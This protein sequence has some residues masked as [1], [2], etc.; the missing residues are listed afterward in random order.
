MDD[1]IFNIGGTGHP[2]ENVRHR[3]G[4][5]ITTSL[6]DSQDIMQRQNCFIGQENNL[7]CFFDKLSWTTKL[8]LL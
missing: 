3:L 5:I 2:I 7:V 6:D 4:H 1:C 8:S